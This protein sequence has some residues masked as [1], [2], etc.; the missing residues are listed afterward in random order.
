MIKTIIIPIIESMAFWGCLNIK[1][2]KQPI[3][4][5][6]K[7]CFIMISALNSFPFFHKSAFFMERN[8]LYPYIGLIFS[9]GLCFKNK[10]ETMN[11]KLISVVKPIDKYC[12]FPPPI[13]TSLLFNILHLFTNSTPFQKTPSY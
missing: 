4:I 10:P 11:I 12:I 5:M 2:I 8:V 1:L 6:I 13:F 9:G 7:P 3:K